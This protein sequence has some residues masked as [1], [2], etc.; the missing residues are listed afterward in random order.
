MGNTQELTGLI[1]AQIKNK[2]TAL[3]NTDG[4]KRTQRWLASQAGLGE[5]EL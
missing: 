3:S 4:L 2:L 5:V 1:G